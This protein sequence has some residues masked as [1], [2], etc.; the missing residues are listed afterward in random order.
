MEKIELYVFV[1]V[2]GIWKSSCA[3]E[4]DNKKPEACWYT[5][6][7]VWL[8]LGL[9]IAVVV[10]I[11]I[12]YVKHKSKRTRRSTVRRISIVHPQNPPPYGAPSQL[13]PSYEV[14]IK[15]SYP[16]PTTYHGGGHVHFQELNAYRLP[17]E[18]VSNP[19]SYVESSSHSR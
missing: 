7:Y 11:V 17:S 9:F 14:A 13:P 2:A 15:T 12:V 19:P 18:V 5:Y 3:C 16:V 6:W 4:D 1:C 8:A 10:T